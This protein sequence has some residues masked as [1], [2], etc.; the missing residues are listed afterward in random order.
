MSVKGFEFYSIYDTHDGKYLHYKGYIRHDLL[1]SVEL[2]DCVAPLSHVLSHESGISEWMAFAADDAYQNVI[3]FDTKD[4]LTSYIDDHYS[5][6][7]TM[8]PLSDINMDT[9][10]G[11]YKAPI[12]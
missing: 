8:H 6:H 11:N 1:S 4:K 12:Q 7:A 2:I 3:S 10:M 5:Y 9:P